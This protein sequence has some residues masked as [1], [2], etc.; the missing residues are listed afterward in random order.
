MSLSLAISP[1][2]RQVLVIGIASIG[3]IIGLSKGVPAWRGWDEKARASES[4]ASAELRGLQMQLR[5][6]AA[7][8]DS[9]AAREIRADS[10]RARVILGESVGTAGADLAGRITQIADELGIKVSSVQIRPDSVF[11]A[12]QA[13]VAVRVTAIGDVTHLTDMLTEL[14]TS[15][16]LFAVRELS[17]SPADPLGDANR[18]ELLRIQILVEALAMHGTGK[19]EQ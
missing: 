14:E 18:A 17:V 9:L 19:A 10:A 15:P 2:D 12:G 6:F 8:K 5:G 11:R 4:E 7:T 1:R 16:T 13:R 3:S